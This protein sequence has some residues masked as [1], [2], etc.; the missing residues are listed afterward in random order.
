MILQSQRTKI[1]NHTEAE[2]ASLDSWFFFFPRLTD[3]E[4]QYL[5]RLSPSTIFSWGAGEGSEPFTNYNGTV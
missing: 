5:E 2:D 1:S 4:T 3:P